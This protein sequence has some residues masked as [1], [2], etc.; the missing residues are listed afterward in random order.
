MIFVQLH[1]DAR[2]DVRS[3][4]S[5][6]IFF[7]F[8]FFYSSSVQI[9]SGAISHIYDLYQ[10]NS[11]KVPLF[12][13]TDVYILC[14]VP[15]WIKQVRGGMKKRKNKK[16]FLI[17]MNP[18]KTLSIECFLDLSLPFCNTGSFVLD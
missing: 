11:Q 8:S 10:Q 5:A 4:W 14:I 12:L 2:T 17:E 3:Y 13:H 18:S 9:R 16:K 6:V 15:V 1:D 7:F